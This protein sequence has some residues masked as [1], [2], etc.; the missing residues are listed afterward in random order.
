MRKLPRNIEK[1]SSWVALLLLFLSPLLLSSHASA[2]IYSYTD[3]HPPGWIDS[4]VTRINGSG[5]VVGFGATSSGER[6]F[7]WS[8]GKVTEILPPG[9]DSAR[10]MWI[11]DSGEVAGTWVK[12]GVR[13]AFLLRGQTYLDPTAG[14]GYSEAT[15]IGE[16]GA[17]GGT[18]EF[19]AFV[20]RDGA[21][22][23][24]PGFSVLVAGN[25]SGQFVGNG[26][27]TARLYLPDQGYRDLTPPGTSSAAPRGI[28]EN[29]RVAVNSFQSGF[30]RGFVFSDPFFVSM[31]PPGWTSSCVTAIN[32]LEVVAG[33]GDSPEGRRS[34][35]RSGGMYEML[36]VPGWTATEAAAL[37][38]SGQVAG[39][40]TTA[41]GETHAFVASPLGPAAAS[42]PVPGTS[43]GCAMA[44]QDAESQTAGS[45]AASLMALVFPLLLL[46]GRVRSR[47]ATPR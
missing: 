15:Y 35:L 27:D 13:H 34:F 12:D 39:A 21:V 45:A 30:D 46:R 40:G 19:G 5:E 3:I 20:S 25:S 47:R 1:S 17:V 6:G 10:A 41:S 14:W 29:G 11:N 36:S 23:I 22:E 42:S 8:S 31:T 24:F 28:N 7:L 33:H 38:D 32:N 16:D 2:Q 4:R 44:P 37:N 26:D 9:A 18:G 43:G